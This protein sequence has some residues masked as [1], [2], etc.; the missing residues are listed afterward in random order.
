[1]KI[2]TL[3]FILGSVA[4]FASGCG[5]SDNGNSTSGPGAGIAPGVAPVS[6]TAVQLSTD[7]FTDTTAQ[8]QTAVE[9][10]IFAN[11]TTLV[12]AFQIGRIASGASDAVGFAT[13]KD[14]GNTWTKG[15]LPGL[16][17]DSGGTDLNTTD[18]VVT[19]DAAHSVWMVVSLIFSNTNSQV[20]VSRSTDGLT[21]DAPVTVA[22]GANYDKCWIACDNGAASPYRGTCYAEWDDVDNGQ[23]ILM[24]RSTDGGV[25]WQTPLASADSATGL[26]GQMAIQ[27][28][29]NVV[30]PF[31]NSNISNPEILSISSSNGGQSW[32]SSNLV[33]A[34]Q[35]TTIPVRGE[36]DPTVTVDQNGKISVAWYDC[37]FETGCTAN[38]IAMVSST[39]GTTWSAVTRLAVDSVGSGTNHFLPT[40]AV[41]PTN[42]NSF[43]LT[44]YSSV[45]AQCSGTTCAITPQLSASSD[46]GQTWSTP[47]NLSASFPISA[48]AITTEG[49]MVGDYF[50]TAF[51]GNT[52]FPTF[53]AAIQPVQSAFNQQI[54]VLP[55]AI[56]P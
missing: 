15:I 52:A 46:G 14:S 31:Y 20:V 41:N 45:T 42:P 18:A 35:A 8:H 6:A 48:I 24:S 44:Y 1:M 50:S 55:T 38:D 29:G 33:V 56:N 51:V 12:S 23:E 4:V 2:F 32:S 10:S 53:S 19:Y 22:T 27:P 43:V 54:F 49:A 7:P 28:Q 16:T 47:I 39:D 30:V 3:A 9:P 13:S 17:T 37:R 5:N 25:T 11:G 34:Q 40:L 36:T 21:W 26:G